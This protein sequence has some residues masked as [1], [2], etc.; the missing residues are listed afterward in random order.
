MEVHRLTLSGSSSST[1][2]SSEAS[3]TALTTAWWASNARP[4]RS[5]AQHLLRTA[6][7]LNHQWT[8][9]AKDN[10]LTNKATSSRLPITSKRILLAEATSES[11]VVTNKKWW[12][13]L[14]D[15]AEWQ[16]MGKEYNLQLMD[17]ITY[18]PEAIHQAN[19]SGNR[20]LL[21]R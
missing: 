10:R 18:N 17:P 1:T 8:S 15:T 6:S 5:Q 3:P 7:G 12:A 11:Q 14:L 13:I 20:T 9:R 21:D 16:C 4:P 19:Q 2:T